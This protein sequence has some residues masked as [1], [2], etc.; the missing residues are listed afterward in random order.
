M[1]RTQQNYELLQYYS[2]QNANGWSTLVRSLHTLRVSPR[3]HMASP[4]AAKWDRENCLVAFRYHWTQVKPPYIRA[5]FTSCIEN[6]KASKTKR[7]IFA[8]VNRCDLPQDSLA[9]F[10]IYDKK[11]LKNQKT[12]Y[13]RQRV[14]DSFW[15][16]YS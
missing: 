14:S 8:T 4:T 7:V 1:F 2:W 6:L 12:F 15:R 3:C 10:F 16:V 9:K 5:M 13:L 11:K